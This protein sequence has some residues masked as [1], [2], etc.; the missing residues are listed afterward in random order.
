[1]PSSDEARTAAEPVSPAHLARWRVDAE[2]L[3]SQADDLTAFAA[4]ADLEDAFE[5]VEALMRDLAGDIEWQ[6]ETARVR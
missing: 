6:V 1:L 3:A 4:F 2:A 5:P